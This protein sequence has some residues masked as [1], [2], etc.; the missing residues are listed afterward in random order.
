[1]QPKDAWLHC[2]LGELYATSRWG[3]SNLVTLILARKH[4]A[5]S[6][7]LCGDVL[8]QHNF[9]VLYALVDTVFTYLEDT[10]QSTSMANSSATTKKKWG[11]HSQQQQPD[12]ERDIEVAK[13]L[14]KFDVDGHLKGYYHDTSMFPIVK[15]AMDEYSQILSW[16]EGM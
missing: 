12:H 14:L 5:L 4:I 15:H 7:E 16:E 3:S 8:S 9:C 6:P 11:G 13:A 10:N 1:M 2:K